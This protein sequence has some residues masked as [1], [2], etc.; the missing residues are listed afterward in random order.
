MQTTNSPKDSGFTPR[1]E[2][3]KDLRIPKTFSLLAISGPHLVRLYS[4]PPLITDALRRLFDRHALLV[5]FREDVGIHFSEFALEGKPWANPKNPRNEKLLVDIV[6]TICHHG[7]AFL[8]TLD[9]GRESDD[10]LAVAFSKAS[11][12][13]ITPGRSVSPVPVLPSSDPRGSGGSISNPTSTQWIQFALSFASGTLLRVINPPLQ[14]TPAILQAVR[15]SWPRGV[16]SEQKLGD[17]LY[18][19][20]LKGYKCKSGIPLSLALSLSTPL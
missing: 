6:T 18:E 20:K 8:S 9:Y 11:A 4:F 14:S 15:T 19:F 13:P 12:S 17:G 7:Y 2:F 5:G 16:V 1:K 10:R 3:I